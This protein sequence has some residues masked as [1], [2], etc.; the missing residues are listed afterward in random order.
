MEK[1]GLKFGKIV[2]KVKPKDVVK[3]WKIY[4]GDMVRVTSGPDKG[5]EGRIECVLRKKNQVVVS[6]VNI[7]KVKIAPQE[8]S[9]KLFFMV[10]K[11]IDVSN[12]SLIDPVSKAP[13]KI[14]WKILEDGKKVRISKNSGTEI[15][16]PPPPQILRKAGPFDTNPDDATRRTFFPSLLRPPIPAECN[17]I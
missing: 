11:G 8:G 7:A 14:I 17:H 4:T 12:V 6:G 9:D 16:L 15:P 13:T 1:W 10:E 2:P 5:A 3:K